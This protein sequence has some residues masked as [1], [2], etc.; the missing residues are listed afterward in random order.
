MGESAYDHG[1]LHDVLVLFAEGDAHDCL[2]WSADTDH[3]LALYVNCTGWFIEESDVESITTGRLPALRQAFADTASAT[4]GDMTGAPLLFVCRVRERRPTQTAYPSDSRLWPL[5]D[6]CGP[7]SVTDDDLPPG[8]NDF[9]V[10][11]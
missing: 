11:R 6:A 1:L 5:L 3:A 10:I 4:G 2:W 9:V 8:P 7:E